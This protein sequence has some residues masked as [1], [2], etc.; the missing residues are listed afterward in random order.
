MKCP[1]CS[2]LGFET[3]DR[4]RNCGYDFS[5]F[6]DLGPA[7]NEPEWPLHELG[8]RPYAKTS[9]D[10]RDLLLM[11]VSLD[12]HNM[13][14]G[15]VQAPIARVATSAGGVYPV[16]DLLTGAQYVWKGEWNYVRLTPDH[17]MHILRLPVKAAEG[18]A[19]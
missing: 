11:I 18:D 6:V 9:A 15:F 4:C 19:A 5:L 13:Q 14:H 12:P 10:G 8:A 16:E 1:K 2:Y 3:G 17:P 7:S